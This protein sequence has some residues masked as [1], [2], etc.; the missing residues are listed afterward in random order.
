MI[1][2]RQETTFYMYNSL[3]YVKVGRTT[4]RDFNKSFIRNENYKILT[5]TVRMGWRRD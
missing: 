3:V 2:E 5:F 4:K 1:P